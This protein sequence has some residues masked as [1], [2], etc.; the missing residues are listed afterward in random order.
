MW[1]WENSNFRNE[2]KKRSGCRILAGRVPVLLQFAGLGLKTHQTLGKVREVSYGFDFN[3][4][5]RP[6]V[7]FFFFS[8]HRSRVWSEGFTV[9][10]RREFNVWHILY[11]CM[12]G[13]VQY[14]EGESYISLQ[15]KKLKSHCRKWSQWKLSSK[16]HVQVICFGN[17][18]CKSTAAHMAEHG[19]LEPC[20]SSG[21][22][23]WSRLFNLDS[24]QRQKTHPILSPPDLP[25]AQTELCRRSL[26]TSSIFSPVVETTV[27][28]A[29]FKI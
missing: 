28:Q 16:S 18:R 1:C 24:F 17:S 15:K 4:T 3:D 10:R 25:S 9:R 13:A 11:E 27:L 21:D 23:F 6:D 22:L 29:L 14:T 8:A 7:F 20:H 2:K 5:I 19:R 26:T 12:C